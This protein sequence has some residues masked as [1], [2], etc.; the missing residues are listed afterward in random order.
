M[1]QAGHQNLGIIALFTGNWRRK[2]WVGRVK[3]SINLQAK[4][5]VPLKASQKIS[6]SFWQAQK[7]LED[8]MQLRIDRNQ[9]RRKRPKRNYTKKYPKVKLDAIESSTPMARRAF[10]SLF[11]RAG[12]WVSPAN[13]GTLFSSKVNKLQEYQLLNSKYG[14]KTRRL[15]QKALGLFTSTTQSDAARHFCELQMRLRVKPEPSWVI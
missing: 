7:V 4:V 1:V 2:K 10:E 13:H 14:T 3:G 9:G 6:D 8:V 12:W 11:V 15:H 5:V